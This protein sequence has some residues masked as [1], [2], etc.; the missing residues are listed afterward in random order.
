MR[1]GLEVHS[2]GDLGVLLSAQL[3]LL[4]YKQVVRAGGPLLFLLLLLLLFPAVCAALAAL[5]RFQIV[6]P[7][8]ACTDAQKRDLVKWEKDRQNDQVVTSMIRDKQVMV[9]V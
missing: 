3:H 7:A 5:R 1:D 2:V 8:E 4:R 9:E 6:V